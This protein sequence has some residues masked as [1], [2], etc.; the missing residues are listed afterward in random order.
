MLRWMWKAAAM[1]AGMVVVLAFASWAQDDE[2]DSCSEAC[3]EAEELCVET[4]DADDPTACEDQ[5]VEQTKSCLE[6]CE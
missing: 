1:S 3:Y 5:C 4:C 6:M 2:P